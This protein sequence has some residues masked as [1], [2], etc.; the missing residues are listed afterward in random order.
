[1]FFVHARQE[2]NRWDIACCVKSKS[3]VPAETKPLLYKLFDLF[4]AP[5][6]LRK[7]VKPAIIVGFVGWFCAALAVIP[8][9]SKAGTRLNSIVINIC[10]N[11][12][13]M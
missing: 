1:M 4:Y 6:L 9:Y 3:E 8:R 13:P 11:L 12:R 5:F 2:H 7:W 10:Q